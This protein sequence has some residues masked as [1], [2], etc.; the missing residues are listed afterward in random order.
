[1]EVSV[2]ALHHLSQKQLIRVVWI[3]VLVAL[4]A[5]LFLI[6]GCAGLAPAKQDFVK[7][8]TITVKV[9]LVGDR[10]LFDYEKARNYLAGSPVYGGYTKNTNPPEIWILGHEDRNGFYPDS[11]RDIGHE[12]WEA[13]RF[14]DP[15]WANPH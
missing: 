11:L 14:I 10:Q 7:V 12:L 13:L 6:M 9:H 5:V 3:C 15:E 8:T 4:I 1:M 2:M